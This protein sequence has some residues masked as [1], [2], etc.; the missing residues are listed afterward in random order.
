[1]L[2]SFNLI[3]ILRFLFLFFPKIFSSSSDFN[4]HYGFNFTINETGDFSHTCRTKGLNITE[5]VYVAQVTSTTVELS[6][7][8]AF[9]LFI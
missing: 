5:I 3:F 9:I 8:V 2:L 4:I 7:F 6:F 1:M